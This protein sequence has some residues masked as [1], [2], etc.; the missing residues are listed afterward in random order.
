MTNG[1]KHKPVLKVQWKALN[2]RFPQK[3]PQLYDLRQTLMVA[4]Q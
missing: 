3:Q 4:L 1:Q 2:E